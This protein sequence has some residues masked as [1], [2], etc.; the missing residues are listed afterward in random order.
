MNA[1]SHL[2]RL[3]RTLRHVPP[4]MLWARAGY[5]LRCKYYASPF[6]GLA[7]LW[8]N[9]PEDALPL[10][11]KIQPKP[12][13]EGN[14]SHGQA[15]AQGRFTFVGHELPLGLPP[16]TWLPPQAKA[17]WT[18]HL[19]YHEWLADLHAADELQ[20]ARTLLTDWMDTFATWHAVAWHPYPLSLRLVAWM[21]YRAW[22]LDG[23]GETFST[24]FDD[25][26]LA[27]ARHLRNNVE[28]WLGGN[29]VIKNLKALV[30][31]G[32]CLSDHET[33]LMESL[34]GLLRELQH[35]ILPDGLHYERS[36]AYH[37]QVLE[38]M[39]AVTAL[40]RKAGG[41][42]PHLL[43]VMEKMGTALNI[44]R[45]PDGT[46]T[47]FN[48]GDTGDALRLTQLAKRAGA[49]KAAS[50]WLTSGGYVRLQRGKT[51]LLMNAGKVGPD[52]NPG[53]AH[54]DTLS[55]ELSFMGEKLIVNNGT[56]AYQHAQRNLWRGT[57][58]KSTVTVDGE[59]SAEVW[60]T[61]RVGRRPD[62]VTCEVRNLHEG[63]G[64]VQ[65][66]HNGYRHLGI[67]HARK[68]VLSADGTMLRGEDTLTRSKRGRK[69]HKVIAGFV[70]A[71]DV[72]CKLESDEQALLTLPNGKQ[73]RLAIRGGRLDS[74]TIPYAAHFGEEQETTQIL[75]H[76]RLTGDSTKIEWLLKATA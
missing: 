62:T 1:V 57:S 35:Q 5:I 37:A 58:R 13:W 28:Y 12:L 60:S 27:Q 69:A 41:V 73:A 55:F 7:E 48:D 44:L 23:A 67:R 76:T 8:H 42:P 20:A 29:H 3:W 50:A 52:E 24:R 36:P 68:V 66:G 64:A 70:L 17:L 61:F 49:E 15:I 45:H 22:L 9:Q 38:D 32:I 10:T 65:A 19:H 54:A 26:L 11:L 72:A 53:H 21:E 6:N 71:P 25:L 39:V 31:A 16:R 56:Y 59:N 46:L 75:I 4:H 43:D 34:A 30:Y 14:A 40:L 74:R 47:Q 51:V 2:P 18:F 63:D 33:V